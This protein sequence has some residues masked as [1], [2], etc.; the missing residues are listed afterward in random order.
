MINGEDLERA[1]NQIS[2]VYAIAVGASAADRV[3]YKASLD[4]SAVDSFIK[5]HLQN[6]TKKYLPDID[7]RHE[8]ALATMFLHMLATG[9][10]VGSE[11]AKRE[12]T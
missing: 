7:P 4:R 9:A 11:N 5:H 2:R 1:E 6:L 3:C 8:P 12:R 10:V